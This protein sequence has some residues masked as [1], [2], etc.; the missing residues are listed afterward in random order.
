MDRA[1]VSRRDIEDLARAVESDDLPAA[2]LLR[3]LVAALREA[4]HGEEF[5]V[6]ITVY[7]EYLPDTF[8]AAF[9]ADAAESAAAPGASV[10]TTFKI[11]K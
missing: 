2:N 6:D 7:V 5:S 4:A 9:V 10:L 11:H 8:D 1:S 3:P